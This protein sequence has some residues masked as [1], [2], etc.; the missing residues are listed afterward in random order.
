MDRISKFLRKLSTK[1]RETVKHI[2]LRVLAHDFSNLDV[3]KLKGDDNIF[4]VR[5][6][7]IRIKFQKQETVIF[8][9][10]VERRSDT[11]Y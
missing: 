8:I 2:I 3:K 9:L 6:G 11:T 10:S 1:E 7:N 4:R 5:K